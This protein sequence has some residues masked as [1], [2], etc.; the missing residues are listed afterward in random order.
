MR[1]V[2]LQREAKGG[3]EN[4]WKGNETGKY[5]ETHDE[6]KHYTVSRAVIFMSE[7]YTILYNIMN[8]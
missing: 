6:K 4:E 3:Y 7:L 2:M 5:V 1:D 8:L